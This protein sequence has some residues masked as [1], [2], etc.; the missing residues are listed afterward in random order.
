MSAWAYR[1]RSIAKENAPNEFAPSDE[2]DRDT[3]DAVNSFGLAYNTAS[4]DRKWQFSA[5]YDFSFANTRITTANPISPQLYPIDAVGRNFPD[6][7]SHFQELYLDGS[8]AFRPNWSA[9]IRYSF[10]PY[11]LEDFAWDN[12]TPYLPTQSATP[13][14]STIDPQSNAVRFLSV[15]SRYASADSHMVGVYIRYTF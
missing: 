2:W 10:S 4:A 14:P 3:R 1:Y 5:N 11:R 12:L 8:Y 9:G 6:V 7:E 13:I 15:N